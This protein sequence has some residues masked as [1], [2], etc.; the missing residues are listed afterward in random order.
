MAVGIQV[1]PGDPTAWC[2]AGNS[3]DR[4]F[5]GPIFLIVT[6]YDATTRASFVYGYAG[7]GP[8][9]GGGLGSERPGGK[10]TVR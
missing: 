1:D 5:R 4:F 3:Q 7:A 8:G 6:L 10:E 9:S 2:Q